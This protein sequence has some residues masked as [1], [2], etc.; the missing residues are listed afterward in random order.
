MDQL[1]RGDAG[2]GLRQPSG[3]RSHFTGPRFGDPLQFTLQRR[4]K[5][6]AVA[7]GSILRLRR[8]GR[9]ARAGFFPQLF[10]PC[11]P[12]HDHSPGR[13][14]SAQI[15]AG[16]RYLSA[17]LYGLSAPH[18]CG[19]PPLRPFRPSAAAVPPPPS[20]RSASCYPCSAAF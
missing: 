20:S 5:R 17:R 8:R 14:P 13:W 11:C 7:C 15:G 9:V 6:R 3:S 12:R 4:R 19:A 10:R 16:A 2:L 1:R 18:S